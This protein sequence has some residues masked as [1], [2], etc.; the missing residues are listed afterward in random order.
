[1]YGFT[2]LIVTSQ[3]VMEEKVGGSDMITRAMDLAFIPQTL[4]LSKQ[5]KTFVLSVKTTLGLRGSKYLF[6]SLRVICQ[7]S[8]HQVLQLICHFPHHSHQPLPMIL[9]TIQTNPPHQMSLSEDRTVFE[10]LA[11]KLMTSLKEKQS[12]LLKGWIGLKFSVIN[13][14]FLLS[15]FYYSFPFNF[16]SCSIYSMGKSVTLCDTKCDRVTSNV[17]VT[18]MSHIIWLGAWDSRYT[19][20][21]KCV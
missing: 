9:P 1:M 5:S 4:V 3:E 10:T 18:V 8:K 16:F 19:D 12:V 2:N 11:R 15:H 14:S 20:H 6:T 13:H 7:K 21:Q 17:T